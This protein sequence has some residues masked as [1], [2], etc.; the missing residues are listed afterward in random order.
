M[1]VSRSQIEVNLGRLRRNMATAAA[2]AARSGDDIRLVAVTKSVGIEEA[3]LLIDLGVTDLAENRVEEARPKIEGIAGPVR[4]HMIGPVQRRKAAVVATLFDSVD[5]VDR[6]SVAEALQRR[7]EEQSKTLSVLIEVNVSGET[8]KHG[9]APEELGSALQSLRRM[10]HLRVEGLMTMAPLLDDAE[11]TRPFFA[12]LRGLAQDHG[13]N[14]LS[15]GMSNDFEVAIEEGATQIR[16][17]TALF[18]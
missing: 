2:R 6:L 7:C 12:L 14:E 18:L 1:P 13:L 9:F 17:G 10:D 5:S 4:W 8:S 3:R 11:L 16:V 15:M